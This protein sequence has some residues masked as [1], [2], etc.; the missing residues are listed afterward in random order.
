MFSPGFNPPSAFDNEIEWIEPR[1]GERLVL[2]EDD[3]K[4][5]LSENK[6]P[7]LGFRWSVNPYRGCFHGC[8]YCYARPSHE[9]LGWGAGTDFERK[10]LIKPKAPELLRKA[11]L[12]RSWIGETVVFSGNTDC[13]QPVERTYRLTRGCLEVCRAFANPV[14]LIT[15]SALIARDVDVLADLDVRVTFSIP[16]WDPVVT[17]KLE[18]G[19]PSPQRRVEAMR[20][21]A[22]A[23]V[24]V[25]VNI[26]PC[27][28][29]VTEPDIPHI[30]KAA[31][32]AGAIWAGL[33]SLWLPHQTAQVF[34][35]RLGRLL[36]LKARSI[37]ERHVRRRGKLIETARERRNPCLDAGWPATRRLFEIHARRL[38]FPGSPPR[39]RTTFRR[40]GQQLGL[41]G[42]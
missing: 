32:R 40:P 12:R 20:V 22:A 26:A 18:P 37:L 19:A 8:A 4:S 30:L 16:T 25:G 14:G 34:A 11:F 13:Y 36:P 29:G 33:G 2:V 21:L 41:F 17:R 1:S 31:Q 7:D 24:P 3:S 27:I 10:L 6:S 5:I 42:G 35:E 38:G 28:P 23:G 39:G 15:R 9:Y